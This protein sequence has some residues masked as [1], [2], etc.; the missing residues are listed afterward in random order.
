MAERSNPPPVFPNTNSPLQSQQYEYNSQ[1]S[2]ISQ[3]AQ[4]K[5]L[6]QA[7]NG[8]FFQPSGAFPSSVQSGNQPWMGSAQQTPNINGFNPTVQQQQQ[9]LPP[10]M[11][12]SGFPPPP[13]TPGF[14]Y[15]P[16]A[17]T[18]V[19]PQ[20]PYP[21]LP[22]TSQV[23]GLQVNGP[24]SLNSRP[25]FQPTSNVGSQPANYQVAAQPFQGLRTP[26]QT[27][28]PV[29]PMT[30]TVGSSLP[31]PTS[32]LQSSGDNIQ[33]RPNE[34][35]PA[36]YHGQGQYS[37]QVNPL[38]Q[39][40]PIPTPNNSEPPSERS[41]RGPSPI[42]GYSMDALEGQFSP[43]QGASSPG[44][45]EHR[46]SPTS[47][48]TGHNQPFPTRPGVPPGQPWPGLL[49]QQQNQSQPPFQ[50]Q[51]P[52]LGFPPMPQ[53][54]QSSGF[55]STGGQQ[56]YPMPPTSAIAPGF[57]PPP[58]AQG[59]PPPPPSSNTSATFPSPQGLGASRY[60]P[61]GPGL[62]SGYPP[63]GV[64]D[65]KLSALPPTS[66][67][68]PTSPGV[69][70]MPN[71]GGYSPHYPQPG[72]GGYPNTM[73][74]VTQNFSQM[75]MQDGQ[76]SINL[77]N[78]RQLFPPDG[79]E[80]PRPALPNDFKKVNCSPDIFRCT[81]NAIPQNSALLNKARLPLGILIHPF[82]DLSQL[83][84]IQSSVIVRCR[85]C[86]TYINPFVVFTDQRRWKCNLCFR[87]NDL[88]DEFSF[89]P[90]SKT[91]G[92]PQRRPE[93]KSATIEFIAPSE[94]MLRPPQPAVYLFLLDVSFNAVKTGY[95]AQFCQVLL[96][97]LDKLPG[98]ARTTI[99]FLC[100]DKALYY[101]NLSEGLSQPQMMCVPDLE[102]PFLPC[103]DNLLVNLHESKEL[104]SDLL[105]QLP[106]LFD[107]NYE[108]G[109]A[110]G[111]ALQSAHKLMS[112]TGGRITVVQT[113]L[114]TVGPG[115]LENRD[116]ASSSGKTVT[117]LGPATDFY[118]KLSL[119]CSAQQ[120]AVDLF[121]LNGQ[122]ADIATL[123]CISKFSAGCIYYYP[124]YHS[125][126][127]PG[128][129]E[130][131]D[132]DLRRYLTRKIGFESVMRIRCTRGLSI[133][134]FH[135]N[136]F[137]RS[138]DLLSL[139]N[140]NPDA[141]FGMQMSIED[142]LQE[143]STVSFQ[144][145]LLYTS[146]KGERRIR[147]HTLC[148]PV[149][150]QLS[151]VFANADQQAIAS[152]LAKM[153]VDRSL[154]S[155]ISDARDAMMNAS[156]DALAA[157]AQQIP[158]SQRAGAVLA[159]FSLRLMP[160]LMLAMLKSIAFSL[161]SKTK[162][163]DRVFAMQ[164]F[165]VLP[166]CYLIQNL[167]PHLYP[168]LRISEEKPIKRG[169]EEIPSAPLLQLSSANIDRTGLFLMD[170]GDAM[171]LLVGSGV[172]DQ[173]CQDVFDKPNFMSIP[174][175]MMDL[176]ELENPLSENIRSFINYLMDSRP[177]GVTFLVIRDDSKN[178][179][180]FFQHMLEDRTENSMSYYE[181][182]QFLQGKTKG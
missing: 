34:L 113:C 44:F 74:T 57:P 106:N 146:S 96:D 132:T 127:N 179:Q 55:S 144:A 71:Q 69:P 70:P 51:R 123:A 15:S 124:S 77:L 166:V 120:I 135:G 6:G 104:I 117:N 121:M 46:G 160:M 32:S 20:G 140:I 62:M 47:L 156:L 93:V 22:P 134:T 88:P 21:P 100:F 165:K 84:V 43:G 75:G 23:P 86:R 82:R 182:L 161:A 5:P 98:D 173:I 128:L 153:A 53:S 4:L 66:Q 16:G 175:D 139:P 3:T 110:L 12:S 180:L 33:S 138:T 17:G 39:K 58:S 28:L 19:R 148:V 67:Y 90:V 150:N 26:L 174:D 151:D 2:N 54:S 143:S 36:P 80:T 72:V 61:P 95:L 122:Y 27:G 52:P 13:V 169:N 171:C 136:F 25:P 142:N 145:A 133:H 49:Q 181:F 24:A 56:R 48:S 99:G 125:V 176:P 30:S 63:S 163:D 45:Q 85:A 29:R 42:S 65:N 64:G 41:S 18:Q 105:N 87:V 103:P 111:A 131:F 172:G 109:S 38:L 76:R 1:P 50:V 149:T 68:G 31:P 108:T 60:P 114:P 10:S 11:N 147:V 164:Q 91:Y 158:A 168:L 97:E 94:Y 115:A 126:K 129:V 141:G 35:L 118:K 112:A 40:T 73:N 116:A 178:R 170:T 59:F 81:L 167:Y 89:D 78:E 79:M 107:G 137:V 83:P 159:P 155:A 130:K 119:D 157:Y 152:L 7:P 92:D 162:I 9:P 14:G 154:N 102:D 101:F 37:H 177:F 8:P